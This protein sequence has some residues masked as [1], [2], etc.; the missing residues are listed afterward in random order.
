MGWG[1]G[2][3]QCSLEILEQPLPLYQSFLGGAKTEHSSLE[4]RV[5]EGEGAWR[6]DLEIS[7]F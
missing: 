1:M 7:S 4:G 2:G 5:M 3:K 6:M